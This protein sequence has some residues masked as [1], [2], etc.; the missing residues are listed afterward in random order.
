MPDPLPSPSLQSWFEALWADREER[1]YPLFF[2][3]RGDDL[4][5]IPP[6]AFASLGI[7]D[8]DPRFLTHGVFECPPPPT[9]S[10][11]SHWIYVSSGMSN[12]WGQTPETVNPA[13]YSGLGYEFTL[14]T[15]QQSPW[16]IRLLHWVMAVQLAI[17]TGRMEGELLQPND[18]IHLGGAL[19]GNVEGGGKGLTHLLVTTPDSA[20]LLAGHERSSH[21][22]NYP[23]HFTLASG[24][25]DFLLLMGMTEREADF[26]RTQG[27]EALLTLFH[28]HQLF[29]LTD[30][31]RISTV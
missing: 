21:G 20:A 30:P 3:N 26:A 14:H 17:A 15:P 12:P 5:T 10:G 1:L 11:R 18:R 2:G 13:D 6:A 7:D 31:A 9:E 4:A 29:P 8:P 19:P 24:R 28:H 22:P 27:P 16:A 23:G 25:V